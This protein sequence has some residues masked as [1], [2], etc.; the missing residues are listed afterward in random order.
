M[1]GYRMSHNSVPLRASRVVICA[2]Y[3]LVFNLVYGGR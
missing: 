2:N 1:E 3:R